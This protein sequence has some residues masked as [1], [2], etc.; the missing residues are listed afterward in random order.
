M[1]VGRDAAAAPP[2]GLLQCALDEIVERPAVR[3]FCNVMSSV[4]VHV[5]LFSLVAIATWTLAEAGAVAESPAQPEIDGRIL[6]DTGKGNGFRFDG[7]LGLYDED[8]GLK[9]HPDKPALPGFIG[10]GDQENAPPQVLKDL[11]AGGSAGLGTAPNITGVG[12]GEAGDNLSRILGRGPSRGGNGRPGGGGPGN[13]SGG[14]NNRDGGG[15]FFGIGAVRGAKS[16]VYVVDRSGSMD[17]VGDFLKVELARAVNRLNSTQTFN[18]VWFSDGDPYALAAVMVSATEDNKHRLFRHLQDVKFSGSTDPRAALF[19][20]LELKP[21]MIYILT[22][23]E[24]EPEFVDAV[25]ARNA[26]RVRINAVG[27]VL[28]GGSGHANLLRLTERN[29]G[30]FKSVDVKRLTGL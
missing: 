3:M 25:T 29:A 21:E 8:R 1:A 6:S 22:D 16:I 20:A 15:P 13:G 11:L 18:V 4:V 14:L 26:A 10:H 7:P 27:F 28:E 9:L 23:G 12:A 19:K 30:R 24:F 5:A 17:N 2:S